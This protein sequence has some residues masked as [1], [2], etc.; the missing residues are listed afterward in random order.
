MA[1][2]AEPME[3]QLSQRDDE[4]WLTLHY[5]DSDFRENIKRELEKRLQ[6]WF[7]G[8]PDKK[9]CRVKRVLEDKTAIVTVT[10][11]PDASDFDKLVGKCLEK[12]KKG[13]RVEAYSF[14][15]P[16]VDAPVPTARKKTTAKQPP[17]EQQEH[18]PEACVL[19]FGLFEYMARAH[20]R[21]LS[22]IASMNS[23]QIITEVKVTFQAAGPDGNPTQAYSEFTDLTQ[24]CLGDYR[25][26]AANSRSAEQT[27]LL[28]IPQRHHKFDLPLC[29]D[30]AKVTGAS[31]AWDPLMN[32]Q[33]QARGEEPRRQSGRNIKDPLVD[34]GLDMQKTIW[35]QMSVQREVDHL[36]ST[37]GVEMK[38]SA[39]NQGMIN[40][41]VFN[42]GPGGCVSSLSHAVRALLRL[43]Q[44][45]A[46]TCSQLSN[47]LVS[48]ATGVS[49][50]SHE[51]AP[52]GGAGGND[53]PE[54][55]CPICLDSFTQKTKLKCKHE[56]CK[57]CLDMS[58]ATMGSSCPMCKDVFGQV[59]GDQ[60]DGTMTSEVKR[61]MKIP[62]YEGFGAIVITYDI[63][64]GIQTVKHPHPGQYYDGVTRQA[65]LPNTPEG[66]EV[67]YLLKRAFDQKLIFTVGVSRTTGKDNQVTWNDIHHK[68]SVT[69]GPLSFGYPDPDY[70]KRVQEELKAK[71]IQ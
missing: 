71:G 22:R 64:R 38:E 20:K 34:A 53:D 57:T 7:N 24:A 48:G 2:Q 68:T 14:T 51:R 39:V 65:F 40:V 58:I 42:R 21:D 54:D 69:G 18:P 26:E 49:N 27:D 25:S 6:T 50:P 46:T 4:V 45:R 60:P 29:S 16:G 12:D 30:Q 28:Q 23:V 5:L 55:K 56:F 61:T 17:R 44:K 37:F 70:L 8:Q 10:P 32:V 3:V 43:Y 19:P 13:I 47:G 33:P 35:R 62:G 31:P 15:P 9:S 59:V 11:A 63:P 36:K 66:R 67:L 52:P 1:E 41:K